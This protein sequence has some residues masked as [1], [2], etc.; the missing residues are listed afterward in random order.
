MPGSHP[1]SCACAEANGRTVRGTSDPTG[2]YGGPMGQSTPRAPHAYPRT[3]S[4]LAAIKTHLMGSPAT[5]PLA[6]SGARDL[7]VD[8]L[9]LDQR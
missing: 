1:S 5:R 2:L 9:G 7:L 3:A 6:V 8:L 4:T